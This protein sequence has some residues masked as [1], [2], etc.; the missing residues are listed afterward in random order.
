MQGIRNIN[1][2]LIAGIQAGFQPGS[3]TVITATGASTYTTPVGCRAIL[4][5]GISSGGGGASIAN[6]SAGQIGLGSGGAGG[7]YGVSALIPTC[8]GKT[9]AVVVGASA[10]A[11]GLGTATTFSSGLNTLLSTV[12]TSNG[13]STLSTNTTEAFVLGGL[14]N[15]GTAGEELFFGTSAFAGHRVSGTVAM[16]G[17]GGS[18][19]FGGGPQVVIAQGNGPAGGK[20]GGGGSG[21]MSVNAGGAATG[22]SSGQGILIVWE[23]Y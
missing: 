23:Y 9:F 19:P 10:S 20:Y 21:A 1:G 18:G 12:V 22:G 13:S 16:A 2:I 14:G 7:S 3:R 11:G 4:V 8:S 15:A 5:E 17:R 6:S